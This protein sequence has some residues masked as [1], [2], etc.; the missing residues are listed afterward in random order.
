MGS[1]SERFAEAVNSTVIGRDQSILLRNARG[2]AEARYARGGCESAHDQFAT[3]E[4]GHVRSVYVS[5]RPVVILPVTMA[6]M[7]LLNPATQIITT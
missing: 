4:I 5:A 3:R 2:H 7:R 1:I 6:R